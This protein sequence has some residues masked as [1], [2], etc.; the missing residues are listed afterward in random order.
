MVTDATLMIVEDERIVA[1]DLEEHLLELGYRVCANI[2]S[3]EEA[4]ASNDLER[5]D[6][7]LMDIRL[8]GEIDG[9]EA[10]KRIRE[11][12]YV[13]IIFLTAYSDDRTLQQGK[14]SQ[15]YGYLVKP[16]RVK[17]LSTTIEMALYKAKID[18]ELVIT[19]KKLEKALAEIKT[20]KGIIS[21]CACC[22]K[23][24]ND[25]GYWETLEIYISEHSEAEFTHGI[26][27]DCSDKM[28]SG[29]SWYKRTTSNYLKKD[30]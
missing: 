29:Q 23:I 24:R 25:D 19:K 20:L 5:P 1:A 30:D 16:Y 21:I 18:R 8:A 14:L 28:Y 12:S 22:K 4:I 11:T 7:I 13:P 6:L 17:D 15:P 26:C 27:Q 9:T 3:G 2:A 10:A